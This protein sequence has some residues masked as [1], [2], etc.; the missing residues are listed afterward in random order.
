[1]NIIDFITGENSKVWT[2]RMRLT[3]FILLPVIIPVTA[4]TCVVAWIVLAPIVVVGKIYEH[5][6]YGKDLD[7]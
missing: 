2:W 7:I 3:R 5:I 1:M 6:R 4:V